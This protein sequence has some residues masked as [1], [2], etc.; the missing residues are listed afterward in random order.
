MRKLS[1]RDP[2]IG[3]VI[4]RKYRV[5]ER[6]GAGG[7]GAVYRAQHTGTG[8]NVA[9]KLLHQ[10]IA[11]HAGAVQRFNI[12]A[13][14]THKLHHHNT[15]RV[16]D[17]G[18][19]ED[20]LLF[21]AMEYVEGSSLHEVMNRE[22]CLSVARTVRIIEQVLKSL[23][24][25]H[26]QQII[27]RDIKPQNIMLTDRVGE[28][29]FVKVLDFGVS[30]SL[31]ASGAGTQGYIG[32]PRYMAPEQ[33]AGRLVDARA[34][35]Y[36]VGCLMYQMLS[37]RTP[38]TFAGLKRSELA[39]AYVHAHVNQPPDELLRVA[40]GVCPPSIAHVVMAMLQKDPNRRPPSA[41]AV[42]QRFAQIRQTTQ[43]S[44]TVQ[45]GAPEVDSGLLQPTSAMLGPSTGNMSRSE[46]GDTPVPYDVWLAVI[47]AVC[48]IAMAGFGVWFVFFR[49]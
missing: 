23:G 43:L 32:T 13:R 7:F 15:V 31:E 44:S 11:G 20:G 30:R 17:F 48:F 3:R 12:E 26:Q 35:L 8:G 1:G 40:P 19:T 22:H 14:N 9:L 24:E 39:L 33:C 25:A 5:I 38:F 34:D 49:G 16:S 41:E 10:S 18:T 45:V 27:H 36:S 21:L 46:V 2:Y 42:L 47:G 29:D 37:G 6:L 4:D 28:P